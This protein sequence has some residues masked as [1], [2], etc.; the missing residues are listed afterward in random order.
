MAGDELR[1]NPVVETTE[2]DSSAEGIEWRSLW[3]LRGTVIAQAI[4]MAA[5]L[6]LSSYWQFSATEVLS[7]PVVDEWCD[8]DQEGIG[9]HCFGD[10]GYELVNAGLADPW[11]Q[12][13]NPYPPSSMVLFDGFRLL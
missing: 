10:F 7:F 8:A 11:E 6:L 5:L 1:G 9:S 4:L 3:L 2:V 13:I 12:G